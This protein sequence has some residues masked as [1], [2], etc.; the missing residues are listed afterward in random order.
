MNYNS[1]TPAQCSLKFDNEVVQHAIHKSTRHDLDPFIPTDVVLN[2]PGYGPKLPPEP[3]TQFPQCEPGSC[4]PGARFDP[5]IP[6]G[7]EVNN[8]ITKNIP[9]L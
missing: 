4:P 5:Y 1:S 3:E 9:T 6:P 7:S 8:Y 2:T